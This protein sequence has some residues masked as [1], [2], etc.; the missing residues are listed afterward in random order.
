MLIDYIKENYQEGEPIFLDELPGNSKNYICQE[1][2]ALVDKGILERLYNGVYFL[3]YT[4]ILGTKG[5]VSIDQY[6]SKKYIDSNDEIIGY[7]TGLEILNEYGF[8]SQNPSV[9]EVCSNQASSK[10]RKFDIGGRKIIVY[11]PLA[12]V[13]KENYKSLQFLDMMNVVDK[14]SELSFDE[15]KEKIQEYVKEN[16]INFSQ[17]KEYLPLYPDRVYRNLYIGGLMNELV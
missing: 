15:L 4:T 10:Q 12:K 3:S 16:Q 8:T 11:K 2:K 14:Y 6:V 1:V 13:T 17:V 5:Q 9:I 7:K